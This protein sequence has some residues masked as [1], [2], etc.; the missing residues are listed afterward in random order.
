MPSRSATGEIKRRCRDASIMLRRNPALKGR[1][2]ISRPLPQPISESAFGAS[3]VHKLH[4]SN[5]GR[6]D[7]G[8][9]RALIMQ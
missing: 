5:V 3:F 1:A 9:P 8:V 7:A 2:K 4:S 6:R